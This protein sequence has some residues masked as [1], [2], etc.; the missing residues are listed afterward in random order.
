MWGCQ[1]HLGRV[2]WADEGSWGKLGV[3][4]LPLHGKSHHLLLQVEAVPQASEWGPSDRQSPSGKGVA[5]LEPAP[6]PSVW[7]CLMRAY[8]VPSVQLRQCDRCRK[9]RLVTPGS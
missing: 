2:T 8:L 7:A 9:Q 1:G 4:R 6:G 3:C 5:G